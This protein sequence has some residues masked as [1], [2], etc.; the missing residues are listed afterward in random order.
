[1]DSLRGLRG[2]VIDDESPVLAFVSEY[3]ALGRAEID[4]AR[5][6]ENALMILGKKEV[7]F[8]VCDMKMPGIDGEGFY[9]ILGEKIPSL[10]KRIIFSAGDVMGR[11][12]KA[13][14]NS[15]KNPCIEKPFDLKHLKE[16]I[17]DLLNSLRR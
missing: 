9:R 3:L 12:T 11:N 14:F 7:D 1:V 2:L 17:V 16:T 4:T 15:I 5:D 13:F 8:V 6:I 10:Q